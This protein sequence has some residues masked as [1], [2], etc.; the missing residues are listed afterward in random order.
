RREFWLYAAGVREA[1]RRSA[2]R[3]RA[4]PPEAVLRARSQRLGA[5]LADGP[6][7]VKELGALASGFVGTLGLWVDLVRVPPS[8]TWE[9]RRA[10]RLALAETWV[11]PCTVAEEESLTHLVQA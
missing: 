6:R 10:D 1:R 8:G 7:N 11:G 3:I 4:L 9:R 2:A 5:A